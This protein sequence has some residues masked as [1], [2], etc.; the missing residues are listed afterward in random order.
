MNRDKINYIEFPSQ[1]LEATKAFFE[2]AFKWSFTDYG[3]E[4]IAFSDSGIDGGFYKADLASTTE[5]GSALVVLYSVDIDS[6]LSS[7]KRAGGIIVKD[8]FTFPGGRRFHF[9]EPSGNELAVW[10]DVGA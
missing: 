6:S 4:Y 3:P 2:K 1:D 5:G 9:M 8:I 7:V 10:T